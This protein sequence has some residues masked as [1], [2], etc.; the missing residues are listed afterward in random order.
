MRCIGTAALEKRGC[1]AR[2]SAVDCRRRKPAARSTSNT[3]RILGHRCRAAWTPRAEDLRAYLDARSA[4]EAMRAGSRF[5]FRGIVDLSRG[6]LPRRSPIYLAP[7]LPPDLVGGLPLDEDG[8]H[9]LRHRDRDHSRR[10]VRSARQREPEPADRK[11][12]EERQ[13][14]VAPA[15]IR[16]VNAE[17]E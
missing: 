5:R 3:R 16:D 7:W 15:M 1:D 17:R 14:E 6:R 11:G 4:C 2:R 12:A 9:D 10:R 8:G 13:P